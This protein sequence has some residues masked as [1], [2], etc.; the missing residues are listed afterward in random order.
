MNPED[1]KKVLGMFRYGMYVC[2]SK[3]DE[4]ISASTVTWVTQSSFDPPLI[5][6]AIKVE[7][8]IYDTIRQAGRLALHIIPEGEKGLAKRFF[9]PAS[10]K[11]DRINGVP[12]EIDRKSVV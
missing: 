11:G 5:A 9:R 1:R 3:A 4:I 6:V 8:G 2:T 7:S 10:V 12:F